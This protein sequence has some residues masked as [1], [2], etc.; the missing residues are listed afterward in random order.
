MIGRV[1]DNRP[2]K[3]FHMDRACSGR[4]GIGTAAASGLSD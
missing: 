2:E 4:S 1:G 3:D